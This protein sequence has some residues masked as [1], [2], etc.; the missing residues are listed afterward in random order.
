M[1]RSGDGFFALSDIRQIPSDF[2]ASN[3]DFPR[4]HIRDLLT[5]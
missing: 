4:A 5:S 2:D 1:R 3:T